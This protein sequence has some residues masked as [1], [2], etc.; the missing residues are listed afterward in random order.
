[1][2]LS[3]SIRFKGTGKRSVLDLL[4]ISFSP[5]LSPF[6]YS[7]SAGMVIDREAISVWTL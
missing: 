5:A 6:I 7:S 2:E 1:M 4:A 3:V